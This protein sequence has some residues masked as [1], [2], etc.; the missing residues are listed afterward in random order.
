[1]GESKFPKESKANAIQ[2]VADN[3]DMAQT[4][5]VKIVVTKN[6]DGSTY[7]CDITIPDPAGNGN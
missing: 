6:A 1:M 3:V 4:L 2:I 5:K 7:A